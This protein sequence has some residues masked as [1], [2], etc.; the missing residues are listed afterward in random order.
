MKLEVTKVRLILH[1]EVVKGRRWRELAPFREA[2]LFHFTPP[3]LRS[4]VVALSEA[5][6]DQILE[7]VTENPG[8]GEPES[9]AHLRAVMVDLQHGGM[10]LGEIWASPRTS[11]TRPR[12]GKSFV[13]RSAWPS[14]WN[15][16][17]RS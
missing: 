10:S 13:S 4:Q 2:V 12:I 5:V 1:L 11:W 7:E 17:W 8:Y 3:A 15:A 6:A 14:I 9:R 16:R